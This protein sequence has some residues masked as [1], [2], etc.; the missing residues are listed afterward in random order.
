MKTVEIQAKA[1]FELLKLRD[2]SM[3]EIFA[4][5]IDG[6]RKE[7]VFIEDSKPLFNYQLPET[8]ELLKKDQELFSAEYAEKL[9]EL[10]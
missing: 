3:W 9:R 2:Q 5:M 8:V 4:Q 7:I 6:E 10:N 1:F